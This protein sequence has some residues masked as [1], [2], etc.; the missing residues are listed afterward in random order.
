MASVIWFCGDRSG[1]FLG[2]KNSLHYWILVLS[3]KQIVLLTLLTKLWRKI[4]WCKCGNRRFR[5]ASLRKCR[6]FFFFLFLFFFF[7]VSVPKGSSES[8]AFLSKTAVETG[9]KNHD[10][11]H[12]MQMSLV[13]SMQFIFGDDENDALSWSCFGCLAMR[14]VI[15]PR[16]M[17]LIFV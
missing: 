11:F 2:L 8:Q 17:P 13:M 9:K 5:K 3:H 10:D 16:M 15:F 1:N 12:C 14:D 7:H 6:R 4:P